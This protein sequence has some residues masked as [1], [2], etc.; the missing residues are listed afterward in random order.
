MRKLKST[1]SL[2]INEAIMICQPCDEQAFYWFMVS[3]HFT[4]TTLAWVECFAIW[5][6]TLLKILLKEGLLTM[7]KKHNIKKIKKKKKPI[8]LFLLHS[9]LKPKGPQHRTISI[10]ALWK[11][12]RTTNFE[13]GSKFHQEKWIAC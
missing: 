6:A 3:S 7:N 5:L 13:K 8:E 12:T 10:N 1:Y 9:V 4:S 2:N 11:T